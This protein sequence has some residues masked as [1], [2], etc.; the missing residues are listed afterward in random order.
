ME[1]R[2]AS[3]DVGRESLDELKRVADQT[4]R[5][6]RVT[7]GI[8]LAVAFA[9]RFLLGVTFD[10][11]LLL[12]P[13]AWFALTFP[14]RYG[15][16]RQPTVGALHRL[17]AVFFVIELLLITYLVH[18]LEG[19]EWIGVIFYLFTVIYANFFLPEPLSRVITA[20]AVGLYGT[21]AFL[22]YFEVLP[23]RPLFGRQS[24]RDLPYVVVTV[25][26]GGAGV[27][28]VLSYTVQIFVGLLRA[29]ERALN[30]LSKRL[31]S[32]QEE[33]RRR[34]AHKLHDEIGQALTLAKMNLDLLRRDREDPKLGESSHLLGETFET[35]RAL[36]HELKPPLLEERGL[37]GAMREL[38][39]TYQES[40]GIQVELTF[41][42]F[43]D[44]AGGRGRAR[45]GPSLDWGRVI[46]RACQ[47]ALI[48]STS[49]AGAQHVWLT[50][51]RD[52]HRLRLTVRDDGCG[53][54]RD[55][56]GINRGLGLLG[57]REQVALAG[58]AFHVASHP[59]TGTTL[60]LE[61]PVGED[62]GRDPDRDRR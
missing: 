10:L 25:L 61:L 41:E 46:Y 20:T 29:R 34:I 43:D 45:G 54:A 50:L 37:P 48:N 57:I 16:R 8:F 36:S 5:V 11:T 27:Y 59:G 3:I 2:A 40:Q 42:G 49:H 32:A 15:M 21:L 33:E 1:Q 26:A 52:R 31:L 18:L 39:E 4:I 6:R 19:V 22:E 44:A 13:L 35:I 28:T 38:A 62:G 47:E 30:R 12:A 17:H 9:V 56:L 51:E 7:L 60:Q 58:G 23:H 55:E 14:F 24:Y 53:F